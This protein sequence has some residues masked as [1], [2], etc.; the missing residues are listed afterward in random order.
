MDALVG[1]AY[2]DDK[3]IERVVV[4]KFEP[5]LGWAFSAPSV[6]LAAALSS[7]AG[8]ERVTPVVYVHTGNDLSWRRL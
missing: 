7:V 4:Q 8:S 3:S 2:L 1:V 6:Q 5:D